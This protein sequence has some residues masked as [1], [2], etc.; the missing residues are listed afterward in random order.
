MRLWSLHP[1]YL[2]TKGLVA[3]W[4]EALLAKHVL[5]GKT[6]GYK[7]HPQLLR[8]KASI[9]PLECINFYLSKIYDEALKRG[10]HFDKSKIDWK[11]NV[12]NIGVTSGQLDYEKKHLLKKLKTRDSI[13]YK[14]FKLIDNL[15]IHP[16]FTVIEGDLEYWEKIIQIR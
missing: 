8:F 2:D 12:Y 13:K 11:F 10:Y 5:E 3:L 6:K 7:N 1:K 9:Y 16:L 4:R 14:E 15:E